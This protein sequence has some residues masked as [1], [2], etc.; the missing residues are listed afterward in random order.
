MHLPWRDRAPVE[1]EPLISTSLTEAETAELSRLAAG[2]R[3]L[4]VGSAYG[5]ST[6]VMALVAE[7]VT[8]VDPHQ[9]L[10]SQSVYA[11]NLRAYGVQNVESW[12]DWS[13]SALPALT[14]RGDT[15][16][17]VFID[18][19]HS[20]PGV[21]H[22]VSAAVKLLAPGGLIACHDYGE[23][24]CP[25]VKA[26]LDRAFPDGPERLVDTLFVVKP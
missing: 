14:Q 9:W 13:M 23:D 25:G 2:K 6:V 12:L 24:S 18:G 8:A 20:E 15:F 26:F 11:G 7:H 16:D 1:G 5:Y 19:D 10:A 4:E 17:L 3:V 21:A 22:D